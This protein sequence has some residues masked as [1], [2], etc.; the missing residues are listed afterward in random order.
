MEKLF[1]IVGPYVICR[2]KWQLVLKEM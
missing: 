1:I 2:S